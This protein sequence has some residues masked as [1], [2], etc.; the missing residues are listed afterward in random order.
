[1]GALM[2]PSRVPSPNSAEQNQA[3]LNGET[4][5]A[6]EREGGAVSRVLAEIVGTTRSRVNFFMNTFRKLGSIDYNGVLTV[7]KSL[8]GVVLHD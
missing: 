5:R 8:L 4:A 1:M 2:T 6:N 7:N 3:T